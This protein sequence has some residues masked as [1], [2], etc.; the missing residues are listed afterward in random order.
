MVTENSAQPDVVMY[1]T[2]WCG[3]CQRLKMQMKREGIAFAEVDIE[4]DAAAADFVA[5]Q[6]GGN[7]TVPTL[8]FRDGSVM[9]NPPIREV[10][11]KVAAI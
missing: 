11:E 8:R 5:S 9:T 1:T 4:H 7:R 3:Y 10:R 2:V 6:N